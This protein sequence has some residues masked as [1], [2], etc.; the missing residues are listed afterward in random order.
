MG[1]ISGAVVGDEEIIK[2]LGAAK[3]AGVK[4]NGHC[5]AL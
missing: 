1:E 5:R 3:R 4:V 2:L